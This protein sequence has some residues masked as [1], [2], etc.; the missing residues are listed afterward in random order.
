VGVRLEAAECRA[1]FAAAR[2]A[3]LAVNDPTGVALIVPITFGVV[4]AGHPDSAG[5]GDIVVSA[6]DHKPKSTL[7]LRRLRLLRTDPRAA[8]LVDR[9]E[10]DWDRL[11][12]V[13]VDG[14]AIVLDQVPAVPP[15]ATRRRSDL[16]LGGPLERL[17]QSVAVAH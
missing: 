16:D 11:W 17:D 2:R 10:D 6:I 7:D 15:P 12:W 14:H 3:V 8:L 1:R 4:R 13:R 9:Y 5:A